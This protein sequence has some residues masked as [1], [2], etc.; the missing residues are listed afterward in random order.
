TFWSNAAIVNGVPRCRLS[1]CRRILNR[2][3]IECHLDKRIPS[4]WLPA[5][6]VLTSPPYPGVHVLYHRWQVCGRRETPAPYWIADQRDG[7][8]E[9]YYT[10]GSRQQDGLSTYFS[11]LLS[12]FSGIRAL[13]GPGSLVVQLV[14]FSQPEWQLPLY[15]RNI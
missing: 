3:S 9:S 6:L 14:G 12:T 5:Q 11:T 7:A 2:S 8:G 10:F 4:E 1:S 13:V 15:L